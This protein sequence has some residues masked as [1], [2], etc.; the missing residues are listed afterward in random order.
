[1]AATGSETEPATVP[2]FVGGITS[3]AHHTL[4]LSNAR[5]QDGVV[6]KVRGAAGMGG[7]GSCLCILA[8]WTLRPLLVCC[9]H[10]ITCEYVHAFM[11]MRA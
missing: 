4:V 10:A 6:V 11:S 8:W 1:M 7:V 5:G 2:E 3:G 9:I